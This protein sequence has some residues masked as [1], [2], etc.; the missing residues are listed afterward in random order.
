MKKFRSE[1]GNQFEEESKNLK[2][3]GVGAVVYRVPELRD[4]TKL[5]ISLRSVEEE[6]TTT[7]VVVIKTQAP[8]C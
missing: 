1:F 2:L 3:R 6:N 7:V 4:E 5:K 8:S